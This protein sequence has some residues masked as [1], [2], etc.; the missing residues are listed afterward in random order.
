MTPTQIQTILTMIQAALSGQPTVTAARA[1]DAAPAAPKVVLSHYMKSPASLYRVTPGGPALWDPSSGGGG[2]PA[3]QPVAAAPNPLQATAQGLA[4]T[5][6]MFAP[7]IN[8]NQP[9][10]PNPS[11]SFTPPSAGASV[12]PGGVNLQ[13]SPGGAGFHF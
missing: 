3:I 10:I 11:A 9:L 12:G 1:P 6:G 2:T 5:F 7:A 8:P 13:G 4:D